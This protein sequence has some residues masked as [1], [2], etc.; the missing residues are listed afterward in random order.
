M[1]RRTNPNFGTTTVPNGGDGFPSFANNS[2][3]LRSV[4]KQLGKDLA[5]NGPVRINAFLS[6][7][8]P[9]PL[10]NPNDGFLRVGN[11]DLA[12]AQLEA[13]AG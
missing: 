8:L 13:L 10:R 9:N 4:C 5:V 12:V 1:R 6:L 3:N 7:Q 11:V 2:T